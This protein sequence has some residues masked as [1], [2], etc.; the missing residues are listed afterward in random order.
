M[1]DPSPAAA[2]AATPPAPPARPARS[3][4]ILVAALVVLAAIVLVVSSITVWVKREALNTD[5]W[6]DTSAELLE[7]PAIRDLAAA[8]ISEALFADG[9]VEQAIAERLP[10]ALAPLAPQIAAGLQTGAD[11]A[12][13]QLLARPETQELWVEANRRAHE[14]LV[15]VLEGDS[16]ALQVDDGTVSIDLSPIVERL[17]ARFGVDVQVPPEEATF[18]IAQS[19]ELEAAQNGVKLIKVLSVLTV[20]IV[21][22]LLALAVWLAEGFR[23]ETLRLIGVSLV[24]VGLLLLVGRR[25]GGDALVGA[26]TEPSGRVAGDHIWEIGTELL[27]DLAWAIVAYG[28]AFVVAAWIA[29]PTRWARA[30]RRWLAPTLRE[31]PL[32]V[33]GVALLLFLLFLLWGPTGATQRFVGILVLAALVVTGIELLRRQTAREFPPSDGTPPAD[34]AGPPAAPAA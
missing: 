31:R 5:N 15:A 33:Y 9:R 24:V 22:G 34:A 14:R 26:V 21:L 1:S 12:A 6:T 3:R 11:R 10:S 30:L 28:I 25:L 18:V 2:T 7:D 13:E 17:G 19:D 29:G 8:R 4:R 32:V 16:E 23:R 20:L 27:R